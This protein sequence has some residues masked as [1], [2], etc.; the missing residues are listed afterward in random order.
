MEEEGKRGCGGRAAKKKGGEV[1]RGGVMAGVVGGGG[2]VGRS[3]KDG[4]D[5]WKS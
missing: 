5:Q 2:E 4:E 3:W 1:G